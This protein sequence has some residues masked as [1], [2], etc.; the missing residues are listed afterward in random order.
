MIN[1]NVSIKKNI[2]KILD[3]FNSGRFDEAIITSKKLLKK[4]PNFANLYNVIG[5]S[6]LKKKRLADAKSSFLKGLEID[7]NSIELS[8][9]LGN[10][11]KIEHSYDQAEK[12]FNKILERNP[13]YLPAI[14]SY[15]NLKSTLNLKKE[16]L[17]LYDRALSIQ[18][19]NFL[20]HYN[21]AFFLQTIA[22]FEGA[23]YHAKRCLELNPNFTLAD[24]LLSKMIDHKKTNFHLDSME[25]KL[26]NKNLNPEDSANL[27]FSIASVYEKKGNLKKNISLIL[28]ANS[29]KR[30]HLNYDINDDIKLINKIKKVFTHIRFDDF[31][32]KDNN[33]KNII[34]I[35]GMPR[36][37]STLIEQIVSSH[38]KV[39]GAGELPILGSI[40]KQ[41]FD[42][43]DK[44]NFDNKINLD[45][46]DF[47]QLSNDYKKFISF[48]QTDKYFTTDKNPSNFLWIGF[49]K[50]MFP[51]A[52]I[53]HSQR[54]SRENCFSIFKNLFPSNFVSWGY[55]Q[56]ELGQ[57][58]NHYKDLMEF[59]N[60]LLPGF[61]YNINYDDL[62]NDNEVQ[63]K[64]LIAFCGL[65]WEE[66][67]LNFDKNNT[68]IKTLSV[69][70]ARQKIYR[71]SLDLSENYKIELKDL[72]STLA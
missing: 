21:K 34:F 44:A 23:I 39:F 50:I 66:G 41:K 2:Q 32:S 57:Y 20:I 17:S 61:I 56:L 26:S 22:D 3:L 35:L 69:T 9:N 4:N 48:F 14:L 36:S 38:S 49:I 40:I 54:H 70:Q 30:K 28:E 27:L 12:E 31:K 65:D 53:I 52:K 71:S 1:E 24:V 43:F 42:Y 63:I 59:W 10:F 19:N 8:L 55:D 11:Y 72:F 5:L 68:P 15:A 58:Y 6:F 29:L 13:N 25:Q 46:I 67:C 64:K 7:E 51:N 37:G 62:V 33:E 60:K 47:K 16:S 45:V 18:E